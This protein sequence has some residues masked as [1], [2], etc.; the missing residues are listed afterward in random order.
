MNRQKQTHNC[1]QMTK[2]KKK[3][4]LVSRQNRR[5]PWLKANLKW[6]EI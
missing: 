2:K 1:R 5:Q 4:F 3:K 6:T